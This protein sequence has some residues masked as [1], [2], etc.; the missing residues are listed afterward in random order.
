MVLV[1]L[2]WLRMRVQIDR[3]PWVDVVVSLGALGVEDF[4][5]G[6]GGIVR[7]GW[8]YVPGLAWVDGAC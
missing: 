5:D 1:A 6:E 3:T 4:K 8:T 7:W 2:E